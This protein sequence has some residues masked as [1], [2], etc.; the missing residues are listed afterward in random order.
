[1]RPPVSA[2]GEGREELGGE[3]VDGG[4]GGGGLKRF[5]QH[6]YRLT[7]RFRDRIINPMQHRQN[8][9]CGFQLIKLLICYRT[10][11]MMLKNF[12]SVSCKIRGHEKY[13]P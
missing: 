6:E 1:L 2:F 5:I 12:R 3:Y 13:F 7:V 10:A 9:R 4:W 8:G 11:L